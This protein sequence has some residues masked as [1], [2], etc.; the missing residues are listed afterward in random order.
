MITMTLQLYFYIFLIHR[1][2]SE[3]SEARTRLEEEITARKALRRTHE[4]NLRQLREGEL[5][6]TEVLLADLRNR[7]V[8]EESLVLV[9]DNTTL[10]WAEP[11]SI[12]H[13]VTY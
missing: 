13:G 5:R 4:L 6:R 11:R 3:L 2:Q 9:H 1:L 12:A 8:S 7:W 10:M